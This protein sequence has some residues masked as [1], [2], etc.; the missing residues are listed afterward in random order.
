MGCSPNTSL[1]WQCWP[2]I[3][4][5]GCRLWKACLTTVWHSF[6]ANTCGKKSSA[7]LFWVHW[8]KRIWDV[9][10]VLPTSFGKSFI[11]QLFAAVKLKQREKDVVLVASPLRSTINDQVEATRDA[12]ISAI[13]L[14]C[15]GT[16]RWCGH[17]FKPKGIIVVLA[18]LKA[19]FNKKNNN[20]AHLLLTLLLQGE[21]TIF[22]WS[23]CL[24]NGNT[25]IPKIVRQLSFC[26]TLT[27]TSGALE[28]KACQRSTMGKKIK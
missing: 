8:S 28:R 13:A 20:P 2:I 5:I 23:F 11:Y 12:D 19:G 27:N 25:K 3:F 26:N 16:M 17:S 1:C 10:A 21:E 18:F 15:R 22:D 4:C 7:R 9:V 24:R 6:Q 14:P